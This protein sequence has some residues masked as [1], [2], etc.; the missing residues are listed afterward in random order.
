MKQSGKKRFEFDDDAQLPDEDQS[1]EKRPE[2][3]DD[4]HLT[5]ADPK[6]PWARDWDAPKRSPMRRKNR[7]QAGGFEQKHKRDDKRDDKRKNSRLK[8]D[9]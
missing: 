3:D 9:W 8:Y 1:E 2:L 5:D 7:A 6:D 4:A